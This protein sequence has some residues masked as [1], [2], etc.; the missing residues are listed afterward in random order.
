MKKTGFRLFLAI[1]A[2]ILVFP[3][4]LN[5]QSDFEKGVQAFKNEDFKTAL[6]YFLRYNDQDS[7]INAALCYLNLGNYDNTIQMALKNVNDPLMIGAIAYSWNEKERS[8]DF[9]LTSSK[10]GSIAF[11]KGETAIAPIAIDNLLSYRDSDGKFSKAKLKTAKNIT[12]LSLGKNL[13][14]PRLNFLLGELFWL[15]DGD[16]GAE[17]YDSAKYWMKRS[18]KIIEKMEKEGDDSNSML[19]SYAKGL[20]EN[21]L[22]DASEDKATV[23]IDNF[24]SITATIP[25]YK[26]NG[27]RIFMIKQDSAFKEDFIVLQTDADINHAQGKTIINSLILFDEDGQWLASTIEAPLERVYQTDYEY[28]HFLPFQ[29][30]IYTSNMFFDDGKRKIYMVLEVEVDGAVIGYS[31]IREAYMTLSNGRITSFVP[32][33]GEK[34]GK[35]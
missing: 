22:K 13:D 20:I 27:S 3:S 2:A 7:Q 21:T 17:D 12:L 8:S 32:I 25:T 24:A 26:C 5:A 31:D 1:L 18:V 14:N 9:P 33:G 28:S 11:F 15:G 4:G 34:R 29:Q 35:I 6:Q 23:R 19:K 30:G 16:G 10:W